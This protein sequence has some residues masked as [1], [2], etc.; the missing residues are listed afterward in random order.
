M[1]QYA[2]PEEGRRVSGNVD[3]LKRKEIIL[4]LIA[5]LKFR[6]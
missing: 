4:T 1:H 5:D 2:V 3:D 6:R